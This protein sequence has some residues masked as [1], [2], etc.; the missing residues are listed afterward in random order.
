M[1]APVNVSDIFSNLVLMKNGEK[2][3]TNIVSA[4]NEND[5]ESETRFFVTPKSP[6]LLYGT[7]YAI[8]IKKGLKPKYGT[9][10]L[11]AD[12]S[13]GVRGADFLS[14]SQVFR[15]I[16]DGSGALLDTREYDS[17]YL[18]IP[19]E[20]VFFR[21]SFMAEVGLDKNLFTL[22]T[23][24]GQTVD[25]SLAYVRQT[26]YDERGKVIGDEENRQMIDIAPTVPLKKG[27]SYEFGVN[28]K[29]NGS[30]IADL[31]KT[32]TTAP[33]FAVS[34]NVFLSNTETCLFFNNP[35]GTP[36]ESYISEYDRITTV[37]TSRVQSLIRDEEINWQTNVKTYRCPQKPGQTSYILGTRFEP[38]KTYS[39]V[40]PETFEDVYGNKLGKD[41]TFT[42][43]TGNIDPKDLYLYSSLNKPVQVIPSDLPIVLNILSLNADTANTE[44]CEMDTA[45]YRDYLSNGYNPYYT[46]ICTKSMKKTVALKNRFW[47]LT[48]NKIDLEQD[49][50]GAKSMSPF[51]FVRSSVG[52]FNQG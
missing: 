6:P 52:D 4:K 15:K 29:A 51:L 20:T 23:A 8:S 37:P 45:G 33:E 19:S 22:R 25:F 39:I 5:T 48:A 41:A 43:K 24:S 30:L 7:N 1:T 50:L 9:E 42:V 38:Q 11:G 17:E 35:L 12:Y 21:Q 34:G 16:F 36:Y 26:K 40:I 47:N 27:T 14:S 32:F 49:V 18:F 2:L 13:K 3:E 28:K 10:P 46:P 31:V 44:V